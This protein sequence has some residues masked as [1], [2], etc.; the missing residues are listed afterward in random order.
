M[1]SLNELRRERSFTREGATAR[2]RVQ[3]VLEGFVGIEIGIEPTHD[4]IE[5]VPVVIDALEPAVRGPPALAED[6]A[7]EEAGVPGESDGF[8]RGPVDELGPELD[9]ERESL[10]ANRQDAPADAVA[11]LEQQDA[12]TRVVKGRCCSESR[13]SATEN[14][15]IGIRAFH[16]RRRGRLCAGYAT[17]HEVPGRRKTIRVDAGCG[18]GDGAAARSSHGRHDRERSIIGRRREARRVLTSTTRSRHSFEDTRRD[19]VVLAATPLPQQN[20]RSAWKQRWP[21]RECRRSQLHPHHRLESSTL[22]RSWR[23]TPGRA[24]WVKRSPDSRDTRARPVCRRWSSCRCMR[25]CDKPP[26][27]HQ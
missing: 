2:L 22:R 10:V 4:T 21:W 11:R 3:K 24:G 23:H 18:V 13:G 27:S 7:D 5:S 25:P 20:P 6:F 9:G 15:D 17:V 19:L 1:E 26:I 8:G 14:D 16:E 12:Y